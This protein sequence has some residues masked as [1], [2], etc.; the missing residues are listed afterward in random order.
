MGPDSTSAFLSVAGILL[1]GVT[2][3]FRPFFKRDT[4]ASLRDL[5]DKLITQLGLST[6][7]DSA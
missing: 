2:A 5:D 6:R 3:K 1:V 7:L 4:S